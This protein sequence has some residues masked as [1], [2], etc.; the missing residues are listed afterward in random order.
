MKKLKINFKIAATTVGVLTIW[1]AVYI[2]QF[3]YA[4]VIYPNT[5]IGDTNLGGMTQNEAEESIE[6]QLSMFMSEPVVVINGDQTFEFSA[7]ELGIIYDYESIKNS[8][9]TLWNKKGVLNGLYYSLATNDINLK[10][11]IDEEQ[12]TS[13]ISILYTESEP[14]NAYL[15][16]DQETNE[17]IIQEEQNGQ[18]LNAE[19]L[20]TS[21][22]SKFKNLTEDAIELQMDTLY[23]NVTTSDVEPFAEL[24]KDVFA[25]VITIYYEDEEWLFD[26][27]Q[28]ASSITFGTKSS[29]DLEG[30]FEPIEITLEN[31]QDPE[32]IKNSDLINSSL[33][34]QI[35]ESALNDINS[36]I[37]E[38]I[39]VPAEEVVITI[40][41][42]ENIS[43][44]GSAVDGTAINETSFKS[45]LELALENGILEVEVPTMTIQGGV[46]I[47]E[48]LQ[49]LGITELI[50]T[51]YTNFYGS[52]YNRQMNIAVGM[53]KFNG[54]L[55]E[56]G[57]VFSFLDTLGTVDASTGYYKEL[58]ITDNET[59]P[60]YGGGLCQVSSTMFRAILYG[61]LPIVTRYEHS[62]AVSYYAYPNGYGLDAT[63]YQ[64]WPDLQFENDTENYILIQAYSE[65]SDAYF[66]FYGT[67]DDRT[68]TMDGPYYSNYTSP[69]ADIL[70][71]T[72]ELEPGV[73]IREDSA[74]TGFDVDWYR[75][76]AFADGTSETENIHSHY[77]AW[78][79]KYLVGVSEEEY[80]EMEDEENVEE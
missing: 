39:E 65:G 64:P 9:P 49:E 43:F 18:T 50:A 77:Q 34:I 74:H 23:P 6:A 14:Q 25:S 58:V 16:L 35:E 46:N 61:G 42:N 78:P 45:A 51:G 17:I 67:S 26:P 37:S 41:E 19:E 30:A 13:A 76:I 7:E 32:E 60:E 29:L 2:G 3:A 80:A 24:A 40:D 21:L 10:V 68:V 73:T 36:Q 71:Y 66:K 57:E 62:Y 47:P 52:P 31:T 27:N 79:A 54:V 33:E 22:E 75:T 20:V 48:A 5:F 8:L 53:S 44:E 55:V 38:A 11:T 72:T 12:L 63:I 28:Y 4:S 69:P 1:A 15:Y 70:I 56:P 59:R